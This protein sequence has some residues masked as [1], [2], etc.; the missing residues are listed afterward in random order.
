MRGDPSIETAQVRIVILILV[1]R[2]V[3]VLAVQE[4]IVDMLV[5]ITRGHIASV[6]ALSG[7]R[8]LVGPERVCASI[9]LSAE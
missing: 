7:V 9:M 3:Q 6:A 8:T 4:V 5:L 2:I 1:D